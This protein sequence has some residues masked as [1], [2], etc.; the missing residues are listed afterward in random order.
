[1]EIKNYI[2][3]KS[4]IALKKIAKHNW[5]YVYYEILDDMGMFGP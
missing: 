1:M 5:K 3:N 4:T 2:R